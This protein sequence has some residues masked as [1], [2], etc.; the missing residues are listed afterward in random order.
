MKRI[1]LSV[2]LGVMAI[3]LPVA[4]RTLAP[5]PV[6]AATMMHVT[7]QVAAAYKTNMKFKHTMAGA[8]LSYANHESKLNLTASHLPKP[9]A[10]K[11][12]AYVVWLTDGS[13]KD[14]AGALM[15]HG[16]MASLKAT[17][18]M[19]KVQDIV[20]TAEHSATTKHPMGPTVLS[21]MVG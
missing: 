4:G 11:A 20:V 5:A 13:M 21:G 3:A 2:A 19:S 7:L 16:G 8:T 17:V 6:Q 9:S 18:M 10:I 14:R 15:I 1:L 12:M